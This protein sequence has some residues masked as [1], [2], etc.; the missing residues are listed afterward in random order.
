MDDTKKDNLLKRAIGKLYGG[1]DMK[2]WKVIVFAVATAALTAVFLILPVFRDTSFERMG[3]TF[4]AWIFFAVIIMANCRKPLESAAK[5]F[6]FFLVSQP[7]IYL[8]QV[9]FSDMGWRLFGYYKTWFIWTL[10]TIPMAYIGWYIRKKN[11]LSLLIL[12]PVL[13]MLTS[14]YTGAF[15]TAVKHFPRL[16]VTAFFCLGQVLLYL[17][18]FTDGLTKKIIGFF[19]PLAAVI[20]MLVMRPAVSINS[21]M[22]LPD[23]PQ[24]SESAEILTAESLP[25]KVD[26]VSIDDGCLVHIE[27]EHYGSFDFTVKDGAEEYH[28]TATV[29]EDES[30][31]SQVNI[32]R[33]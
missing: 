20:T 7:L 2:W 16:I 12:L 9:P 24:L 6:V 27:A 31:H 11:W 13:F 18:A 4:E 32:E 33:K 5:T 3:V 28:Y 23:D 15:Q 17:Y 26:I 19:L 10:L 14:D 25:A 21:T 8:F 1:I 29:Y 22:F 30:G